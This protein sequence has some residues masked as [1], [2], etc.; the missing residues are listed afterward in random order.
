MTSKR[1]G[2]TKVESERKESYK[3]KDIGVKCTLCQRAIDD[4]G[5][6]ASPDMCAKCLPKEDGHDA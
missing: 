3:V 5:R 6:G 1:N 2:G 4:V